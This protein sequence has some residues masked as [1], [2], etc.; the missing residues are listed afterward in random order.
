VPTVPTPRRRSIQMSEARSRMVANASAYLNISGEQF[1]Q[2]AISSALMSLCEHDKVL[3]FILLRSGGVE[4]DD[5]SKVA[6]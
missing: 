5:L 3:S 6:L 4:F 2:A 1:I